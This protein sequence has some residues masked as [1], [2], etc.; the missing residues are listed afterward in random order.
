[1]NLL[2]DGQFLPSEDAELILKKL[3][4]TVPQLTD[5]IAPEGFTK[6]PFFYYY[7]QT[8]AEEYQMY[9]RIRAMRFKD[10]KREKKILVRNPPL[11]TFEEFIPG[12]KPMPHHLP[13]EIVAML[14]ELF[15]QIAGGSCKIYNQDNYYYDFE[16]SDHYGQTLQ[17]LV[18]EMGLTSKDYFFYSTY[19]R[20]PYKKAARVDLRP[21]YEHIFKFLKSA[22]INWHFREF[23]FDFILGL[24]REIEAK[25]TAIENG[26]E[27]PTFGILE[28]IASF[29]QLGDRNPENGEMVFPDFGTEFINYDK[30]P[31]LILKTYI[32]VYGTYPVGYP[33]KMTDYI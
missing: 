21:V 6:S 31:D 8:L 22:G 17:K 19:L 15:Y 7:H 20:H 2:S 12:Y 11:L 1:M 9:R 26:T 5:S 30:E 33:P 14:C 3:L 13:D 24:K 29:L 18:Y 27:H 10:D 28:G 4:E 23:Y 16:G 32:E 25:D